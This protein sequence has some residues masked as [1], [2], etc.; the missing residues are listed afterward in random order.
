MTTNATSH[1]PAFM[2]EFEQSMDGGG[3]LILGQYDVTTDV[4]TVAIVFGR[5]SAAHIVKCVNAHD[6][7]VAALTSVR[8]NVVD[9]NSVVG[10]QVVAA[11]RL[12]QGTP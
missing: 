8:N 12:A 5:K 2:W 3:N 9:L 4:D 1:T 7:L 6:A 10:K 11:L